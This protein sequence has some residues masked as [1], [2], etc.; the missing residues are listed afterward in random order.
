MELRS[1]IVETKPN[2]IAVPSSV[3]KLEGGACAFTAISTYDVGWVELGLG[4]V[5]SVPLRVG[6]Q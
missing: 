6:F 1:K 3:A 4:G 5:S 2:V